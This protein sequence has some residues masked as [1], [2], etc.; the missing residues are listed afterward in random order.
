MPSLDPILD[1]V[2]PF[3][4]VLFRISGLMVFSPV[5]ASSILPMKTRALLAI[6]FALAIY[7]TLTPTLSV[8]VSMDLF[9]LA[10]AVLCETLIGVAMGLMAALPMYAVQLGGLIMGQQAGM[11]LGQVYNPALDVET[12]TL[13][14]FLQYAALALFVLMGGLEMLFVGLGHTFANVPLASVSP[15]IAP[16]ELMTGLVA[17]G[18]ELA[19]RVSAPVLCIILVETIASALIARTIPQINVQSMGFSVKVVITLLGLAAAITAVMHATGEDM[20]RTLGL[21]TRWAEGL[22]K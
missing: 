19:L 5:L 9:W 3:L 6:A 1:H 21:V 16:V 2:A 4:L 13:G 7:P 10:P 18:F 11:S 17:S 20:S 22:G 15:S 12:D 14:Q 8:P